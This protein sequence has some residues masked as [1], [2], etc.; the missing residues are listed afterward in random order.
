MWLSIRMS[1]PRDMG[2]ND[3]VT[4]LDIELELILERLLIF[5]VYF[6]IVSILETS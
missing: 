4:C 1:A 6:F 3:D 5:I 2:S